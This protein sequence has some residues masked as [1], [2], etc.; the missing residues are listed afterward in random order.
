MLFKP[1]KLLAALCLL[2]FGAANLSAL[3]SV[4]GVWKSMNEKTG[5]PETITMVYEY[6]GAIYGRIIAT[7]EKGKLR[8]TIYQKSTNA[9]KYQGNPLV[10]GFDLIWALEAKSKSYDGLIF[11]PTEGNE[12]V[13][14]LWKDGDKLIVRGQ[15][16]LLGIG[17]NQKW[18]A[19]SP[20]DLPS[21]FVMPDPKEF[22]PVRPK[23]K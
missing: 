9:E 7:F 12:Y 16:K 20:S 4:L 10:C 19:F 18:V 22:I 1:L 13:C 3:D 8:D 5:E 14:K 2:A 23:R 17:R 6:Q 21:D 15:L 11:H